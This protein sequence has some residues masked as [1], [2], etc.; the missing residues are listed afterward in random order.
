METIAATSDRRRKCRSSFLVTEKKYV[1]EVTKCR[2]SFL[3]TEK[4]YIE[5]VLRIF[6]GFL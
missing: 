6:W 3:V 2:S 1:E 5:E 4:K